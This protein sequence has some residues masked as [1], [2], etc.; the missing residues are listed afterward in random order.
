MAEKYYIPPVQIAF[1]HAGLGE[2]KKV[3]ELF[4][5]AYI[6]RSWE[7]VFIREEPWFDNLHSDPRFMDLVN[8]L[9]F[10]EKE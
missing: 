9:Q 1:V 4:E 8:R 7:L 6:E 3:F 10:P 2:L 5:K